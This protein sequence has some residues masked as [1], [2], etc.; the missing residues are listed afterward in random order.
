[1]SN[2]IDWS[3]LAQ[4]WLADYPALEAFTHR[5]CDLI[6]PLAEGL[7]LEDAARVADMSPTSARGHLYSAKLRE[8]IVRVWAQQTK[9]ERCMDSETP[10]LC[11]TRALH[12]KRGLAA[13]GVWPGSAHACRHAERLPRAIR[14]SLATWNN[15][16]LHRSS[17]CVARRR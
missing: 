3:R 16:P 1:M 15:G 5:Q 2:Q 14:S 7:S 11:E 6:A 4:Q 12:E 9:G 8:Q 13:K 17:R 10:Q